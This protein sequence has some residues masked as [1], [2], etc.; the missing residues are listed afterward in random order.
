MKNSSRLIIHSSWLIALLLSACANRGI[1]PQ[2]GPR[3]SIPPVVVKS[4]PLNGTLGYREPKI[5][6]TFDEYILLDNPSDNVMISPPQQHPADIRAIGKKIRV[7]FKEEMLDST[8]YTIDFGNAIQ[9]NNEK[10]KMK[11]YTFSF[12]T[13]GPIDSLEIY[14]QLINAEDLN[15][16]SGIVVGIYD[17]LED[18]AFSTLPFTRIGRTDEEGEFYIRNIH[19]GTYRLFALQDGSK[20][21]MYQPG[22]GLAFMEETITPHIDITIEQ[23]TIWRTDTVA[24]DSSLIPDSV[25]T[26]QY[27]Y[28][29][30]SNLLLRFFKEDKQRHYFQ[31]AL[32]DDAHVFS[33][34]F[35]A[36]QTTM[37]TLRALR[38]ESDPL[39]TDSTWVNFLDYCLIQPS[40]HYDTITYWLTDS[41][42]IRMDSI[43]FEMTYEWSDS[44][45]NIIPKTDTVLAIYRAP[46]LTDK[47]RALVEKKRAEATLDMR[48]NASTR[49]GIKDT[50][51]LLLPTPLA[52]YE[53]EKIHLT[54][55]VD[56]SW[57]AHP[58]TATLHDSI[59]MTVDILAD[60]KP[61]G[62]YQLEL[63]SFALTDIYGLQSL[64]ARFPLKVRSREEYAS[65]TVKV[66][67]CPEHAYV[68]L[69]DEQDKVV[70][71]LPASQLGS[72]FELLEA[73]VYY[74]RMF[75]DDN[76][77]GKWTTGDW[78]HHRQPEAVYYSKKK[79]NLRA[80][81]DFEETFDWQS[82]PLTEQK[83]KSLRK[84]AATKR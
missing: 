35:S 39:Q 26:S 16:M 51:R 49:F 10:N 70:R 31:R 38:L 17:N 55:H 33:L 1:G 58:F 74:M 12:T 53:T 4:T 32:R 68:Q 75:V 79:L 77:D 50:L 11:D 78:L 60:L 27:Y 6:I 9:D 40:R 47:A 44:L 52:H 25:I 29:E 45:Y 42:A 34:R 15:P 14:G 65:L 22:E 66:L 56:T 54:R 37:P 63:D 19:P 2:G 73:K 59:G 48:C 71:Q 36:P 81:W 41:A 21:Y 43:R 28:F 30:P 76:Q 57:V 61:E 8:T 5:E 69:V 7:E 83:P 46:R 23:D 13:N 80:N 18:S 72:K 64:K 84:D 24:A 82:L 3:D 67:E 62:E 20:D